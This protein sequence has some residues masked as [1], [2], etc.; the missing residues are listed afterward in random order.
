MSTVNVAQVGQYG[1]NKDLSQSELPINV[2]TDASNVRFL[3]GSVCQVLGYRELYPTAAVTPYH[4]FPLN[5]QGVKT[6]LYA[7]ATKIYTV[8]NGPVHT[9]ITRQT[10]STDVDYTAT[11]NSWTSC[12]LGGIP[13]LNNGVD[14]P[15]QWL[16]TGKMTALAAWPA[17]YLC[18]VM[19][20]YKNSLIA[21]NITKPGGSCPF[22]VKWS[23]PADPGTVPA[24][25]DIADATKDAGEADLSDGYDKIVDGLVL[26]D[27]F[28]IYKESSIWRMDYIGG[29]FVYRFSKVLGA[30]G[31]LTKNCIAELD[32]QHFVL[33]SNDC[34]I[35]DGQNAT[36]VLDKQTRREL[37]RQI[38]QDNSS[39]CFVFVNRL[40]NE[41]FVCYPT[42]GSQT[43]N[44]AMVWNMVDKT[45]SF[46]EMPNLTHASSGAVDDTNNATWDMDSA[47]WDADATVWDG[48]YS[49]L[50]RSLSV[51]AS[52]TKKLYLLDSGPT[53]DGV[54]VSCFVERVGLSFGAPDKI[55]TVTR[56]RPRIYGAAGGTVLVSVG[57]SGD[58]FG[59][60]TYQP[61]VPFVIGTTV[62]VDV[63]C[64]GRY[65]AIKFASG[66]AP[67]WRL[68]SYDVEL[69][70]RGGF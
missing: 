7:G 5:V 18:A 8:T 39:R 68:D 69:A 55:K 20:T 52:D 2:W 9:N 38:D 19:R 16:L 67:A 35:H 41:V 37:F 6:W 36:S 51:M 60:V 66:T 22:M 61:A 24:T 53:F 25:W 63:F 27:S 44:R 56:I 1:V 45:I 17:G 29:A 4:V 34:L 21:L 65:I 64:T 3:D 13:V 42:A 33:S 54:T 31:A 50:T 58:P 47:I 14:V 49:S 10:S 48:N 30:S 15:Q 12:L 70:T 46:R 59:V 32:G 23:H 26:R 40:Y 57:S 28:M 43:C 11:R 62:N